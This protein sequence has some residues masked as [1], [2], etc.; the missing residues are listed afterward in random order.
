MAGA[1]AGSR[2]TAG[3]VLWYGAYQAVHVV[4]N[5]RALLML[6]QQRKI[7]FP[8]PPP[9]GGWSP[10]VLD[11]FVAMTSVD[12]ANAILALL[13]V[14][15]FFRASR[16]HVWLGTVTLTVSVY[17]AVVF[18]VATWASGAWTAANAPAYWGINVAFVP[19]V[20]LFGMWGWRHMSQFNPGKGG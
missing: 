19:I 7:D 11:F 4:V 9:P 2:L 17:A 1:P 6:S 15:G 8:A 20:L 3:F 14:W 5:S 10:Q 18:D 16:W 13:F 12:L